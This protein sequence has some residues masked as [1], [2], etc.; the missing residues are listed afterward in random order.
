[1]SHPYDAN[2]YRATIIRHIDADTSQISVDCG[3]DVSVRLTVR[4]AGVDAPER[5]T[6]AGIEA[7]ARVNELLPP[8][9]TCLLRTERL[10]HDKFGRYLG[11]FVDEHGEN[12]NAR[13]V[14]EGYAVPYDGGPRAGVAG[15]VQTPREVVP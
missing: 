14:A 6:V 2:T 12:L 8:G 7:T 11:T 10:A 1:M 13:L 15:H 9:S 4:W 3:L 5:Y